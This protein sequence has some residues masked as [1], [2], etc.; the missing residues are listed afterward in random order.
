MATQS[1]FWHHVRLLVM[2]LLV[3]LGLGVTVWELVGRSIVSL[4]YD[5][6]GS[7]VT[8]A[9]DV[10]L[11]LSEFDSGLRLSALIGALAFVALTLLVRFLLWRR[12]QNKAKAVGAEAGA[13]KGGAAGAG[14]GDIDESPPPPVHRTTR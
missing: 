10:E 8:C 5:S 3:G 12:K 7:S 11:A 6:L 2:E 14:R 1:K 9:N 4:R 13:D